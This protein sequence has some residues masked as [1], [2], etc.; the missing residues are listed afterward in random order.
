MIFSRVLPLFI[1][2]LS[3]SFVSVAKPVAE[4]VAVKRAGGDVGT[5]VAA[6][7]VLTTLKAASDHI[8]PQIDDLIDSGNGNVDDF[9]PLFSQLVGAFE[10]ATASLTE[11]KGKISTPQSEPTK[12]ELAALIASIITDTAK[13]LKKA[14][15]GSRVLRPTLIRVFDLAVEKFLLGVEGIVGGILVLLASLVEPALLI[16]VGLIR[17]ASLLG[18]S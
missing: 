10:T 7:Q 5:D 4:T 11:L 15:I 12:A 8:L 16:S 2:G 6:A 13:T 9:E 1:L 3:F 14:P 18:H 17:V